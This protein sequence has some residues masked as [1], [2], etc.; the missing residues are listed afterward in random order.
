MSPT[1]SW[2]ILAVCILG[3]AI[4]ILRQIDWYQVFYRRWG[5]SPTRCKVYLHFGRDCEFEDGDY[6]YADETYVFYRYR[7]KK[8]NMAVAIKQSQLDDYSYIRGRIMIH[9]KF[10][11]GVTVLNSIN[12]KTGDSIPANVGSAEYP[13]RMRGVAAIG[14]VELNSH[15]A[16]KISSDLINTIGQR[17][18]LKFG[19]I[20]MVVVIVVGAVL[21]F[22]FYNDNKAEKAALLEQQKQEQQLTE[23]EIK[24]IRP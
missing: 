14:A 24:D 15:V 19:S 23:N 3:I 11:E 8:Q 12:E 13:E 2:I 6:S 10:G 17:N 5:N 1:V 18:V 16:G 4:G 22:K 20:V 9:V 7:Y 21:F